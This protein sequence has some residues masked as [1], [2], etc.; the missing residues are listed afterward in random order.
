M[1]APGHSLAAIADANRCH[2]KPNGLWRCAAIWFRLP[3]LEGS[4]QVS[5]RVRTAATGPWRRPTG[6]P[7][8]LAMEFGLTD[9]DDGGWPQQRGGREDKRRD[10]RC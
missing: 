1:T 5:D 3:P 6:V 8:V 10:A 7:D 2:G 4:S 9:S